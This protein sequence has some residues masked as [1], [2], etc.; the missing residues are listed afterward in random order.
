MKKIEVDITPKLL[1]LT[2]FS[3]LENIFFIPWHFFNISIYNWFLY[4]TMIVSLISSFV[5]GYLFFDTD[6]ETGEWNK[7]AIPICIL[8]LCLMI[9]Q[10][11]NLI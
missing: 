2:I 11:V 3:V 7:F 4:V 8:L 6:I 10:I 5:I 9:F 1:Y